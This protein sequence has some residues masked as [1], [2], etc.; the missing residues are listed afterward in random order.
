MTTSDTPHTHSLPNRAQHPSTG[1]SYVLTGSGLTKSFGPTV[2]L[3]GVSVQIEA[4]ETTAVMGPSG[5]GKSTLLHLLAGIVKPD[6]GSIELA[7]QEIGQLSERARTELRRSRFG[8]VFQFGQL[9]PELP[10]VENVALPLM[11]GGMPRQAAE[12]RARELFAP[13]GLAGM[14][15]RRPGEL[16]GGQ[17]QR[18]AVARALVTSPDVI[19]AD[20]PTGSLDSRT[21]TEVMNV[22]SSACKAH[23]AALVLVTH[24][25]QVARWCE[26]T[27]AMRDG[28]IVAEYRR[29]PG[30]EPGQE[31]VAQQHP[32]M[33]ETAPAAQPVTSVLPEAARR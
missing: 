12:A 19:F 23:G 25:P 11:L 14:E 2:A 26:R 10:A 29:E 9:L 28:R 1:N 16:S 8:F 13:L 20:E 30:Q 3:G 33:P 6:S 27:I 18:V 22:L 15:S 32:A 7:G 5:S 31:S 4:G 21:G 24:D 17:S